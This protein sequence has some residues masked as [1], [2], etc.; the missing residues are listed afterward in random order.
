MRDD[1]CRRLDSEFPDIRHYVHVEDEHISIH[2]EYQSQCI[3]V[4]YAIPYL[5]K[6]ETMK[7]YEVY[8]GFTYAG[9]VMF[10]GVDME[11]STGTIRNNYTIDGDVLTEHYYKR[12]AS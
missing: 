3:D 10:G 4:I 9:N 8:L 1:I 11:Y 6:V 7:Y 2:G 5:F 12:M